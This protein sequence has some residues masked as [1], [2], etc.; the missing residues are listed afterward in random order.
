MIRLGR[1]YKTFIQR[2]RSLGKDEVTAKK[3]VPIVS[4][5]I[6]YPQNVSRERGA[7]KDQERKSLTMPP[8]PGLKNGKLFLQVDLNPEKFINLA[9]DV[10]KKS[11][12][13]ICIT[14]TPSTDL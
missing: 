2:L 5:L 13:V 6:K 14:N 3:N 7:K 10:N 8:Y 11:A 9:T 4:E 12:I 1:K